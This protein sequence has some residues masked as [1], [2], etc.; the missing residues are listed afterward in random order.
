MQNCAMCIQKPK[1]AIEREE[2]REKGLISHALLGR[3]PSWLFSYK[4]QFAMQC[5][6]ALPIERGPMLG[7]NVDNIQMQIHVYWSQGILE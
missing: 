3:L 7:S 2:D 1:V 4:L 5:L 6:E